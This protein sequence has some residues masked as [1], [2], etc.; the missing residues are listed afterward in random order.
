MD[1]ITIDTYNRT[2]L[3]YDAETTDFWDL[4]P[5]TVI[6]KFANLT[7]DRVLD[8]GSGPEVVGCVQNCRLEE[9]TPK[10]GVFWL[11]AIVRIADARNAD[12]KKSKI[13]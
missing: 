2:A 10:L 1:N 8:V 11:D 6:D 7:Q 3:E 4:F 13:C 9:C 5:R 12:V